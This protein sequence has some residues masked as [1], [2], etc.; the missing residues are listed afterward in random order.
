[1]TEV[2]VYKPGTGIVRRESFDEFTARSREDDCDCRLIQCV[3]KEARNHQKGCRYRFAL[4]CA[5]GIACEAH[6]YDICPECDPC[7]CKKEGLSD[8]KTE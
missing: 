6:G 4:T 1:M 8:G 3:C 2:I 5:V 7:T